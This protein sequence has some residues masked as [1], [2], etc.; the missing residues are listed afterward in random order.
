MDEKTA[1]EKTGGQPTP[2]VPAPEP[3]KAAE[4]VLNGPRTE[5][6]VQLEKDLETERSARKKIET[7]NAQLQDEL[8]RLTTPAVPAPVKDRP[9]CRRGP[10]GVRTQ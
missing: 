1:E 6:E 9:S 8:H 2:A 4:V 7:D 10:L 5:R 3:P